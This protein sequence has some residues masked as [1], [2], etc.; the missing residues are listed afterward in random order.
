MKNTFLLL[1]VFILL[2]PTIV[3]ADLILGVHPYLDAKTL[4]T[5][6]QPLARFLSAELGTEVKV[7]VGKNYNSHIQAIGLNSID[8]AFLGP[9]S[10][11]KLVEQYGK[12]PLLVKLVNSGKSF[13]SGHI[14]VRKESK[15]STLAQLKKH[16]FAFGDK[17]STMSRLV[18]QAMLQ[19][20]GVSLD[21]LS[22]YHF[23]KGHKNVALAV[24]T[25]DADAGAVKDEV[26][27]QFTIK[28]LRSLAK[29]PNISEHV[30]VT[31]SDLDPV[32]EKKLRQI[33]LSINTAKI[34]NKIL[35]PIKKKL[36][37]LAS[38]DDKDYDSLRELMS[39]IK[40]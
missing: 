13:F 17:N 33:L 18:P 14:I 39:L 25:G 8:I 29:L 26:Y 40:S 16:Y 4:I 31:R 20:H 2:I 34:V 6:F 24:L 37:G 3:K 35:R 15:I 19:K 38:V 21:S 36:T 11:V 27:N 12:K 9:A 7:R 22:G 32:L 30:F 5:R 1:P 10:Y 28:G 23:F